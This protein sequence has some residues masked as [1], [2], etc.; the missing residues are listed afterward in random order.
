M[1]ILAKLFLNDEHERFLTKCWLELFMGWFTH[2]RLW[3]AFF[4]QQLIPTQMFEGIYRYLI[5][6]RFRTHL[7]TPKNHGE[8][9]TTVAENMKY[10]SFN[11][12]QGTYTWKFSWQY[13]TYKITQFFKGKSYEPNLH[14]FGV[15]RSYTP[16]SWLNKWMGIFHPHEFA[17]FKTQGKKTTFGPQQTMNKNSGFKP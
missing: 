12:R 8:K 17:G 13:F 3:L 11:E 6:E 16:K 5:F 9:L 14:D 15:S 10:P 7:F 1:F 4:R 2:L